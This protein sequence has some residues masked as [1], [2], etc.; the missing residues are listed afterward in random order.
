MIDGQEGSGQRVKHKRQSCKKR[1]VIVQGIGFE[2]CQKGT[3]L[4]FFGNNN[5]SELSSDLTQPGSYDCER[6]NHD[7]LGKVVSLPTLHVRSVTT[8]GCL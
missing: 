5:K 6:V 2:H 8:V 7:R 3:F 1:T 4:K